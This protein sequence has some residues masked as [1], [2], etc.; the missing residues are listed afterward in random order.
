M[1]EHIFP[2]MLFAN[3]HTVCKFFSAVNSKSMLVVVLLSIHK[4]VLKF[5]VFAI[6]IDK[7]E[8]LSGDH[9]FI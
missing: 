1:Y 9:S 3:G 8:F 2:V 6:E 5:R 4:Y 7:L